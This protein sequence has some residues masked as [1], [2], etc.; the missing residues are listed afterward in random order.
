V[1][2][3]LHTP[4]HKIC[5]VT[6]G[7]ADYGPLLPLLRCFQES[8]RIE[9]T[10]IAA[11][12]HLS[13]EHGMT[14]NR[15][16][17]DG[18]TIG[19]EVPMLESGEA[20]ADVAHAAGR[21]VAKFA[22]ALSNLAPDAVLVLGDRFEIHAAAMAATL[23]RLPIIHLCGGDITEGAIDDAIRHSITKLSHLHFVTNPASADRVRQ[24]GEDP[25]RV[26]VTGATS[27]DFIKSFDFLPRDEIEKRLEFK[28]LAR[29]LLVTFHPVTLNDDNGLRELDE[30]LAA[31]SKLP[32]DTA[33]IFTSPNA[34]AGGGAFRDRIEAFVA[35]EK[36]LMS[37]DSLGQTLYFSLLRAADVVVGNSSSGLS[38]APSVNT[39][40]VN[41]GR[42]QAGRLH[43]QS[44]I[45]C[46]ADRGSIGAALTRALGDEEFD[47]QNP[48]GDGG[49]SAKIV[50]VIESINDFKPFVQKKFFD[51]SV[52]E[53]D[54]A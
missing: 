29:N 54:A 9:P 24:M 15:I 2:V 12:M 5:V 10:V 43:G 4:P 19:A 26:H 49:A 46:K 7:R 1:S 51:Q 20:Q 27:I 6:G 41:I 17:K 30:V 25:S 47:F 18:F 53:P 14:I 36:N 44:T 16:K 8:P 13:Q 22:D 23:L 31:L 3:I 38:E 42:R 48:Y 39:V 37:R 11:A 45:N 32:D 21:G 40:C 33:I 52:M 28:L 50:E 35:G 34:D